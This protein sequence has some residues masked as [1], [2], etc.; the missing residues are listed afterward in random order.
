MGQVDPLTMLDIAER[1]LTAIVTG[2]VA[3]QDRCECGVRLIEADPT[4]PI[5]DIAVEL[6][7]SHGHLTNAHRGPSAVSG[8][9]MSPQVPTI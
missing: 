6:G 4:R 7:V 5:A 8:K 1:H 2:P 3:G 9:S